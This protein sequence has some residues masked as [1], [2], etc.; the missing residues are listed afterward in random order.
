MR[1]CRFDTSSAY[2]AFSSAS[3][4]TE[5]SFCLISSEILMSIVP[6][7]A[8]ILSDS[9]NVSVEVSFET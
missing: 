9:V 5:S 7:F 4:S 8:C 1:V 3:L 6:A 2:F